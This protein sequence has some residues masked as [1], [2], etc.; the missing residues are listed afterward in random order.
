MARSVRRRRLAAAVAAVMVAMVA[1]AAARPA[2]ASPSHGIVLPGGELAGHGYAYWLTRNWQIVLESPTAT[3]AVCETLAVGGQKVALLTIG[4]AAPGS[5]AHTCREPSGQPIY[6]EQLSDECSSFQ[7]DHNGFGT[8]DSQLERCARAGLRA[9]SAS[10]MVDGRP[11]AK[12][13]RFIVTTKAFALHLPKHNVFN[14]PHRRGKSVAH[15]WGLLLYG[16]RRGVHTIKLTGDIP[17]SKYHVEA[18]YTI[19]VS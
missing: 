10:V 17:G 7:G 3:P 13:R 16:L 18:T 15:G 14:S 6:V 4:A 9:A 5:Y 11:V 1:A 2:L 8:T 12:F 19:H